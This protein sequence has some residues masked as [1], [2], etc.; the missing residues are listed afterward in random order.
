MAAELDIDARYAEWLDFYSRRVTGWMRL[1][2]L[3]IEC[4]RLQDAGSAP[5]PELLLVHAM[6]EMERLHAELDKIRM[7]VPEIVAEQAS[8]I[9]RLRSEIVFL[10]ERIASIQERVASAPVGVSDSADF[11]LM[12]W[13]FQI[14]NGC[15]VGGGHYAL[16]CLRE[17]DD[18]AKE[19]GE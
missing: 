11:D 14:R 4:A 12:T 2:E 3:R 16:V 5:S 10:Q 7:K 18:N 8:E 17:I 19:R 9:A 15:R 13:T 1:E 6:H